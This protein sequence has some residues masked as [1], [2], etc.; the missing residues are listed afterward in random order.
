MTSLRWT[1]PLGLDPTPAQARRWL[2]DE[3]QGRDYQQTWP[4][5]VVRWVLDHLA[6]F[7]DAVSRAADGISVLGT[8]LVAIAVI[9]L[10]VWVLPK[11]RREAALEWDGSGGAVL[12]DLSRTPQWY[13][14][15]A[16]QAAA[17]GR[18][19]DA[20]LD[21]F[22]AI[23]Q[24]MSDRTLLEDAPG[25]TAHEVGLAV[26]R[27]FPD[28]AAELGQAADAFDAVRYGHRS[29]TPEQAEDVR[30]LDAEL[31]RARPLLPTSL[32]QDLAV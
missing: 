28:H 16:A 22:R 13:R 3:L 8:V 18:Y 23:A 24:D 9:A 31:V 30:E 11:V 12:D 5:A 4:G 15:L 32:P 14:Q 26:A 25:R 27:A 7:F 21:G 10:L 17:E 6:A 29:A 2:A 1:P 19:H 20:V